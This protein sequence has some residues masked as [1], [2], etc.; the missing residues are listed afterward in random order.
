[1]A[2]V[3]PEMLDLP[4]LKK[5]LEL[6][7]GKLSDHAVSRLMEHEDFPEPSVKVPGMQRNNRRWKAEDV[8]QFIE[9]QRG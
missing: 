1:M 8:E 9:A 6:E 3:K 5:R 4:R 2:D 7:Y